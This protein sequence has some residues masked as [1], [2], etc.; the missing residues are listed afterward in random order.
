MQTVGQTRVSAA[1]VAGFFD[2]EGCVYVKRRIV[3]PGDRPGQANERSTYAI[4]LTIANNDIRNLQAVK[5]VYGGTIRKL[6]KYKEHHA[7]RY[8]WILPGARKCRGFIDQLLP[9]SVGKRAQLELGM[10]FCLMQMLRTNRLP[11]TEKEIEER[12]YVRTELMR[13]KKELI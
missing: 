6:K 9:Y 11:L 12:E 7:D 8:V 3:K 2:G 10:K 1:W 5:S 13:Y 4:E